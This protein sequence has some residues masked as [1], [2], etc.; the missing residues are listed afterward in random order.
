MI[1]F[2]WLSFTNKCPHHIDSGR[3]HYMNPKLGIDSSTLIIYNCALTKQECLLIKNCP[4]K[5]E[6]K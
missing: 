5:D 1:N 6:I 2:N 3:K 4:R